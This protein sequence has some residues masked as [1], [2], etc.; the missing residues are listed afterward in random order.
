MSEESEKV[1]KI[2]LK[3]DVTSLPG[4]AA[5]GSAFTGIVALIGAAVAVSDPRSGFTGVGTCLIA[6]ALSFGLLANA[7]FRK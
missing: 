7:V 5:V 4:L 3:T 1:T 6:S 2:N